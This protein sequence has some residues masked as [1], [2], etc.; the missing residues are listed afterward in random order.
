MRSLALYPEGASTSIQRDHL[1]R[2]PT[3]IR[4]EEEGC[5]RRGVLGLAQPGDGMEPGD[6]FGHDLIVRN[7]SSQGS[8]KKAWGN[9]VH[10]DIRGKLS[11][12]GP[13]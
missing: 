11:R 3:G 8:P 6:G 13:G 7:G 4:A 9:A 10:S 1:T 2:D 5:Q 12:Q